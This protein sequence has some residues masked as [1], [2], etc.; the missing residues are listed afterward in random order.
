VSVRAA[1]E[2]MLICVGD[3]TIPE[4]ILARLLGAPGT[5]AFTGGRAPEPRPAPDDADQQRPQAR[6]A[7]GALVVD[8]DDLAALAGAAELLAATQAAPAA[9]AALL[10]E[11]TRAGVRVRVLDAGPDGDGAI[12]A[13]IDPAARDVARWAATR[14]LTPAAL[15]GISL[16]LGL[17]SAVWFSEPTV[18]ARLLAILIL[19]AAF[20][21]GRSG[22]HLA[23]VG[24][25]K[26][27]AD[28]L[29]AASGLVTEFA[30]YAALAIS[31]GLVVPG[32]PAGLNG[33]FGGALRHSAVASFGGAGQPGVWRLA[34]AAL[35]LLGARRLAELCYEGAARASG[36]MFPRPA[37]RLPG[38]VVTLPAGERYAVIAITAVFFGPRLTFD[39]LLAWSVVA[40]GYVLI[41]LVASGGQVT[42]V[43]GVLTAYRGDGAVARRLGRAGRGLLPPLPPLLVGLLVTCDLALLGLANLPGILVL[44]PVMAMLLAGLGSRHP[45]DG[46]LDWLVPPLLLTGEGVFLAALGFSRHVWLPVVFAVLAAVVLRHMDLAYRAR[47]GLGV[48]QDRFGLG[49]DGRMLLAGLAAVAGFVPFAYALLAAYLWLLA[50]WDFLS[51]WLKSLAR[52]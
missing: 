39:V 17:L 40:A 52:R 38:Q 12:A 15:A 16:G 35:L 10:G 25:I 45:H 5:A 43:G 7:G 36:R 33:I 28:W 13:L 6:A 49:W 42:R 14:D 46:R 27:A 34:V 20:T 37:R 19:L 3:D 50:G 23:A 44:A 4:G 2:R 11:L 18:K 8:T 51:A 26:P 48:R 29:A 32:R 1:R 9:V 41:G 30:V 22:A 21:A 47:S 31:A 24:P